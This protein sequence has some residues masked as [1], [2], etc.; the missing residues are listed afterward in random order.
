MTSVYW[1]LRGLDAPRDR[2]GRNRLA[3]TIA[4]VIAADPRFRHRAASDDQVMSARNMT[5]HKWITS[6]VSPGIARGFGDELAA[7]VAESLARLR[8]A[9]PP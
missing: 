8:A 4:R 6:G 3:D 5:V 2:P 7:R 1:V 9:R